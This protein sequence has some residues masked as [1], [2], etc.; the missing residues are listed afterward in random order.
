[1]TRFTA[2]FIATIAIL[3]PAAWHGTDATIEKDGKHVRPLRH[4][5]KVDGARVTIDVDRN[6]VNTGDPVV[7]KLQAFSDT[8]KQVAV[9]MTVLQSDDSFGSRVASPPRA[10]DKE[11]FTLQAKPAGGKVVDTK[12]VM[13]PNDGIDKIDWFRIFVAARGSEIDRL[14]DDSDSEVAAISVLGWSTN[15]F[16]ISIQPKG[17]LTAA[18]PFEVVVRL[19]NS[20]T[21]TLNHHPGI[22]LGTSVGMFGLEPGE[23]FEIEEADDALSDYE[24]KWRPGAVY[25]KKFTVTPKRAGLKSVTF[26][27]NAFMYDEEPGPISA[28]AMDAQTFK[29][30]PAPAEVAAQ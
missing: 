13:K 25:T 27:A 10:I 2:A 3:V 26:I 1:M 8:E 9:D 7:V 29:I 14:S 18:E 12:I 24:K 21:Q 22:H 17:K 5:I 28:G 16:D 30:K 6:L 11:H 19:E 20:G 15:D 4:E 23:D